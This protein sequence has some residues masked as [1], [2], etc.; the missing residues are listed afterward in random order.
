MTNKSILYILLFICL[1]R[2]STYKTFYKP[3]E[4][5]IENRTTASIYRFKIE[6]S[7]PD[8]IIASISQLPHLRMLD[9][10]RAIQHE[11]DLTFILNAIPNPEQLKVLILNDLDL[12]SLPKAIKRFTNLEQLSLNKNPDLD[13][14][15]VFTLIQNLPIAF[16]NLQY[17]NLTHL[18]A[19]IQFIEQL[20]DLNLSGNRIN[21]TKTFTYIA[22]LKHLRS[23]WLT[24]NNLDILP[25]TI[26]QLHQ[27]RN[28]YFEH[29]NIS[30]LP[31]DFYQLKKVW[32]IHAGHNNFKHLPEAFSKMKS[33]LL[34]HINNCEIET[35]SETF[36]SRK[37]SLFGLII[38]N[39]KLTETD[40]LLW[41][42]RFK[43]FF[44]LSM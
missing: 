7:N 33:L 32:V 30:T 1:G 5:T 36:N 37:I 10:S 6:S 27:L 2:C 16:L 9:L 11:D 8:E 20:E 43:R 23:L 31:E 21:D 13:L 44:I 15:Q 26:S 35:I 17:N 41:E 12:N 34:L 25:Q 18:P 3:T 29:N 22:Q 40:K 24:H 39:N 28:L 19:S 42:K 4:T 38:D 14:D